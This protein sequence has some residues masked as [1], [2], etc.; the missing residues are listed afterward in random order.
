M[1]SG[2][3][4]VFSRYLTTVDHYRASGH[5]HQ[6]CPKDVLTSESSGKSRR[7]RL[8]KNSVDYSSDG[9]AGQEIG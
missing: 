4:F 2:E 1:K 7:T 5:H 3:Y 6:N 8:S 9:G